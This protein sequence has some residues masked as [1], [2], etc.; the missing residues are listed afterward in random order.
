M[1]QAEESGK[2]YPGIVK[3]EH[4]TVCMEPGG[5]YL[6][7]FVPAKATK[8]KP[9]AAV[10]ADNLVDW[11]KE[12]G[13]DKTLHAIGGDSCN[14]NTGWEGGVMHHVEEKLQRKLVWIVC[15]LH[16]GELPLRHLI[17][18]LDGNTLSNNKWS[19]HLGKMLDSATD[20]EINPEFIQISIGP[21]SSSAQ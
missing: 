14:V 1:L 19:G 7:H 17:T 15:D 9:H 20:L 8:E 13:A 18:A 12:R 11:L 4:Y 6:W 5:R 3:Q 21:R 16:T 10:I 2:M